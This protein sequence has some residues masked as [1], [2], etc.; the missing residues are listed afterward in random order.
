MFPGAYAGRLEQ[1]GAIDE[2]LKRIRSND[3]GDTLFLC[4]MIMSS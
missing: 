4:S 2:R 1:C 3:S